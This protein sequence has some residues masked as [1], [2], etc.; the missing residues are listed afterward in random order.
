VK[1]ASDQQPRQLLFNQAATRVWS[2]PAL[3][4]LHRV[5]AG[6]VSRV[7]GINLLPH[8]IASADEWRCG[9][10]EVRFGR[11]NERMSGRS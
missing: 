1:E 2:W 11:N 4:F 8:E 9:E 5:E 10:V 6:V 3:L 7:T